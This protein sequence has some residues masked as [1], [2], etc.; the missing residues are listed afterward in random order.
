MHA[1]HVCLAGNACPERPDAFD[2]NRIMPVGNYIVASV[3][4][5]SRLDD[6]Q[7]PSRAAVCVAAFMLDAFRAKVDIGLLGVPALAAGMAYY[8]LRDLL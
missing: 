6:A 5:D 2:Q 8:R 3:P 7:I 1:S 4:L